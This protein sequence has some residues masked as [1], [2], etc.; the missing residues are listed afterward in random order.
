MNAGIIVSRYFDNGKVEIKQYHENGN[1]AYH[2]FPSGKEEWYNEHKK[3]IRR[4][5][6]NC[7]EEWER[8]EDN[9]C[10]KY[11]KVVIYK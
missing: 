4:V 3:L 8:D 6:D 10:L 1:L 11:S 5:K 7:T 9:K 2:K